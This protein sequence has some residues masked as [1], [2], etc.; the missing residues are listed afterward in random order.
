MTIQT[1]TDNLLENLAPLQFAAPVTHVYNPL[2]YARKSYDKYLQ[3]Y[4]QG[5]KEVVMIGMNPGPWGMVQTGVPFGDVVCVKEWLNIDEPV[6]KPQN[7]HPKR[8]VQGFDC[9]KREVSGQR[10]WGWARRRFE[11]PEKFFT[12]FFVGNYCP[13]VFLESSGR[14][15]TPDKLKKNEKEPLLEACDRALK[16]LV[17]CLQPRF[18]IGIGKFAH[19]A[20]KRALEEM[21]LT[22]GEVTHPSPANPKANQGWAEQ[23]DAALADLGILRNP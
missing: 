21:S 19:A 23:I 8:P 20:A 6:G 2:R 14:N 11:T 1:I 17:D 9:E 13:L 15:R 10:L 4:G 22:I 12:R 5:T 18:V 16:A 7:E 3:R